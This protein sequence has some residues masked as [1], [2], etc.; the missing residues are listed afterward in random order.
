MSVTLMAVFLGGTL[1]SGMFPHI[2]GSA[3]RLDDAGY[4][5]R[6][7]EEP[8]VTVLAC[9]TVRDHRLQ[10]ATVDLLCPGL[11]KVVGICPINR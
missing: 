8:L 6:A 10:M 2:G 9:V 5:V 4:G 11:V 7:V 1:R 3:I